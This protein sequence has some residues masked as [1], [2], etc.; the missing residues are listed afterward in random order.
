MNCTLF[1]FPFAGG[2]CY[3]YKAYSKLAPPPIDIIP[4]DL[5]GRG[6]RSGERLLKD[7]ETIVDD[8]YQR[9]K[10]QLSTRY[11]FYGHSMGTVLAYL[12]TK[13]IIN[14]DLPKPCYLFMTG[15][16][17]PSIPEKESPVYTLPKD[18]FYSKIKEMD[19]VP[20]AVLQNTDLMNFFEP[21]FRAD[22]EALETYK[23]QETAPFD[24]PILVM[25]GDEEKITVADA[26]AWKKESLS[27]V[28]VLW[29]KGKH[30]FIYQHPEAIMK[31]ISTKLL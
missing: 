21:V 15:R 1:C 20:D 4:F 29:L 16:G 17:G 31:A 28:E 19:G 9:I 23:Y 18:Q 8:L 5:P 30:F 11:A 14:E 6:L 27:A 24:I 3:S 12:L 7:A 13:R 26:L 25:V 10:P 2:S 22:F